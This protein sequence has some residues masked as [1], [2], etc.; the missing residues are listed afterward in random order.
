[1]EIAEH[2]CSAVLM[3]GDFEM[4]TIVTHGSEPLGHPR[5]VTRS[6][7]NIVYDIDGRPALD[8]A[9]EGFGELIAAYW[10]GPV[11]GG[12]FAGGGDVGLQRLLLIRVGG[13]DGDQDSW[14]VRHLLFR[15]L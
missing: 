7:G 9:S 8:V 11:G 6:E 13:A 4:I 12:E 1:M 14:L 2:A 5:I 15:P 3:A 10:L